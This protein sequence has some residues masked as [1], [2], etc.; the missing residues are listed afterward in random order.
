MNDEP[1]DN[2]HGL[3]VW[4]AAGVSSALGRPMN[5][6]ARREHLGS[7]R[8]DGMRP[9]D[10]VYAVRDS[11]KHGWNKPVSSPGALMHH[12][13][14]DHSV[15]L[16]RMGAGDGVGRRN[17]ADWRRFKCRTVPISMIVKG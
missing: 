8:S 15:A 6:C 11:V 10:A 5:S 9:H 7:S 2:S 1:R 17:P 4:V 13:H 12:R 14:C 3:G 16:V